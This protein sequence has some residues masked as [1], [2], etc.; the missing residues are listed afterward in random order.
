MDVG[1]DTTLI[2][3]PSNSDHDSWGEIVVGLS[4]VRNILECKM[5]L[6]NLSFFSEESFANEMEDLVRST[7]KKLADWKI[8]TKRKRFRF[9]NVQGMILA[10]CHLHIFNIKRRTKR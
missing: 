3:C 9:H 4:F 10:L 7:Q 1:I 2:R 8:R 5:H 6:N